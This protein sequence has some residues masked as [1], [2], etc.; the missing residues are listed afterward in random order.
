M[1]IFLVCAGGMSTSLIA[2][3]M[4]KEASQSNVDCKVEAISISLLPSRIEAASCV[5][6]APQVRHR[7]KNIE[8]I[9]QKANKPVALI[10]TAAYG[11]IDGKAVLNQAL[12]LIAA[13]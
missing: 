8:E 6:V 9:A 11:R 3:A 10:D 13:Q 2:Q 1:T 4:E 7:L 12:G 5:L